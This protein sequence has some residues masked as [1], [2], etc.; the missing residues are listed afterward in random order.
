MKLKRA[1]CILLIFLVARRICKTVYSLETYAYSVDENLCPNWIHNL[2]RNKA[3]CLNKKILRITPV[4]G[5]GNKLNGILQGAIGA[6]WLDRCLLINWSFNDHLRTSFQ[7]QYPAFIKKTSDSYGLSFPSSFKG[8]ENLKSIKNNSPIL[9]MKVGYRDRL[10]RLIASPMKIDLGLSQKNVKQ[11]HDSKILCV[12]LERCILREIL[13]PSSTVLDAIHSVQNEWLKPDSISI[14]LHLRMGDSISIAREDQHFL[15]TS[16]DVRIPLEVL[17]IFWESVKM[18]AK[19]YKYENNT[20]K[21][22]VSIFIATDS[23]ISLEAAKTAL[24]QEDLYYTSG[25]FLHSDLASRSDS[26]SIKMLSDWFL[27]SKADIVIQGPWSSFLEKALVFS[28]QTQ[29]IIRCNEMKPGFTKHRKPFLKKHNWAC[30]L[31]SLRDTIKG[32]RTID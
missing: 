18:L 6:Y 31:S 13:S 28:S 15:K 21:K 26:S 22:A 2:S 14:A 24:R 10:C 20:R 32:P 9:D 23:E 25:I 19:K 12:F 27:L 29:Q 11:L 1:T 7:Q 3:N 17:D 5:F 30:F 8:Y 16:G 4:Q